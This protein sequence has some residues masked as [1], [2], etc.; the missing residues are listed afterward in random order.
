MRLMIK[1]SLALYEIKRRFTYLNEFYYNENNFF[2]KSSNF[3]QF[4]RDEGLFSILIHELLANEN[5]LTEIASNSYKHV[6]HF[7]KI[8]LINDTNKNNCR[9]TLHIW[10]PPFTKNEINQELIHDHR[11]SF[12]SYVLCGTQIH[13]IFYESKKRPISKVRFQKYK[14]LPSITGN[15]HDCFFE[16]DVY[17]NKIAEKTV[18]RGN[19]YTMRNDVIHRIVFPTGNE[20]IISF[21]VRGRQKKHYTYTYN[22]FYPR[23]HTLF[24][25][26]MY[27]TN[28]LRELLKYTLEKI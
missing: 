28:E 26:P 2:R 1:S 25:V 6:N 14:Y 21:L 23:K 12:S 11:F 4:V 5:Y 16:K 19:I 3:L 9:L 10:K 7:S 8:V 22:T 20:P 13:E 17:L 15:I 18:S 24:N 27:T